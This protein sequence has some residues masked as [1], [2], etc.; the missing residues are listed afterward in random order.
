MYAPIVCLTLCQ[1]NTFIAVYVDIFLLV[2]QRYKHSFDFILLGF[3]LSGVNFTNF[4][5]FM[6][7]NIDWSLGLHVNTIVFPITDSTGVNYKKK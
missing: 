4:T 3:R 6:N 2:L 7:I 1:I 5:S